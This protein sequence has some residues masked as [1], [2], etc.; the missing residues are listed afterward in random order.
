ME[1]IQKKISQLSNEL[2]EHNHL[3]YIEDAPVITDFKF[4]QMLSELQDLEKQYPQFKDPN[5]PTQR[6]G[7]GVTKFFDT[8]E[9][10]YPMYSLSNTY[11][12]DELVQW[13]T[14]IRKILGVDSEICYT[15]ELKFD[16]A[17]I[18]LT[19]ENGALVQALTR[20]DGVQGDA[21]TT[22]V[23]TINSIPL[24][25]KGNYPKFFEI[26]GEIILPWMGFHKMNE[27]RA[28]LG[29][30]LYSNPRNTASGSLKLQ[31]S[32]L[33]AERPL[34][35]FLYALAADQL[36]IDSQFE[37]L[38]KARE[39]GFKVPDSAS[40]AHS[41]DE[42]FEFITEW[43]EKRK[44]LPY[45]IDGIVIKVNQFNQQNKLGFT[46]KAPRWAMAYKY[47]AQQAS[48][49][50]L[51]V[52]YQVG[53][54]GA[55]TPVAI[56]KPVLISGT[57]VKRASLHN[58]DQIEKLG[59]RIGDT[60]F[61]EKGGEIIPK[62]IGIDQDKRAS[63]KGEISFISNCPE[64]KYPLTREVGEV[65]H[66]CKNEIACPPQQIGKIQ[67][68]IGRKAMDIEGL[69][70]ET[71]SLLF[72]EGLLSNI[73]DLYRLKKE[74][75]LPLERMAEKSV[76]NLFEG[77]G[78]SKNKPFSKVLFGLG[79]RYVGETVAKRLAK[80]FG[81]MNALMGATTEAL[82]ETEEIGGRIA[83][84]VVKYFSKSSNIEVIKVLSSSGL[85]MEEAQNLNKPH[86]IFKGKK[87]VVSGVFEHYSREGIKSEIESFG[88]IIIS[89]VSSKTNFL[90]AGDGTGPS[91][92]TK[93]IDL[94]IPILNEKDFLNLKEQG[95]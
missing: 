17:S 14:R 79:I 92:K 55:I 45:E 86:S 30:P 29:E 80:A 75:I 12:K 52:Q 37:A 8:I 43:D 26:R 83:E 54:T 1:E 50:L 61:V 93:A 5:S 41:I 58:Q 2:N 38:K 16:G 67:H 56:L 53:R 15:C 34:I 87:F 68:F 47:Q 66:Y 85:Q 73:A 20:G 88:G 77:I 6:V 10:R 42:V 24:K 40:L 49:V 76:N 44:S 13:E 21:I 81:S 94:K 36:M 69:G 51:E 89:S 27:K 57:I 4:D 18:S 60:V 39:W 71:V 62:I 91:K 33:V 9:H 23:K 70:G 35:C 59:L 7:G 48:T 95:I 25:L 11:S 31:D 28:E 90:V 72:H 65:Q 3:Y 22:N 19:Y 46:A 78:K 64:C 63:F 32:S 82:T 74:K 84:S